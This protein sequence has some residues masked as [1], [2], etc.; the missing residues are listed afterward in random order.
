MW[1]RCRKVTTLQTARHVPPPPSP[2]AAVGAYLGSFCRG[3]VQHSCPEA[4]VLSGF[5]QVSSSNSKLSRKF[6]LKIALS[7]LGARSMP[8]TQTNAETFRNLLFLCPIRPS[9]RMF[10]TDGFCLELGGLPWFLLLLPPPAPWLT[11]QAIQAMVLSGDWG[12][13]VQ[14]RNRRV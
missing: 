12:R 5:H 8:P 14:G 10:N 13:S 4:C 6:F 7:R 1:G 2:L 9:L 3:L 11:A